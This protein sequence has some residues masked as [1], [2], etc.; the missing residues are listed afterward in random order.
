MS[1]DS[2]NLA[3]IGLQHGSA[4]RWARWR[5]DAQLQDGEGLTT[6]LTDHGVHPP[7]LDLLYQNPLPLTGGRVRGWGTDVLSLV[8]QRVLLAE[9]RYR[10]KDIDA[11]LADCDALLSEYPDTAR[12]YALRGDLRN[13]R[14]EVAASVADYS[15]AIERGHRDAKTFFSRAVALDGLGQGSAAIADCTEAIALVPE[16]TSAYNSRGFIHMKLGRRQEALADFAKAIDLAPNWEG[17]FVNRAA[18][19]AMNSDF[20]AAIAD[21]GR[22][23]SLVEGRNQQADRPLLASLYGSRSRAHGELGDERRADADRREAVRLDSKP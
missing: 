9:I 7:L 11:A 2:E 3:T 8:E 15:A 19:A 18:C 20:A 10:Q 23:I 22:A 16:Y 6:W 1:A 13:S 14:G 17:P 4:I 21:Y 12:A 5:D